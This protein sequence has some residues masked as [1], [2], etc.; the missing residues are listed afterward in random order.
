MTFSHLTVYVCDRN[1]QQW[2]RIRAHWPK[3]TPAVLK[4]NLSVA[5]RHPNE[6]RD[7]FR[8]QFRKEGLD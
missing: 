3:L 4:N 1:V 7:T 6:R 8:R 5:F 2:H